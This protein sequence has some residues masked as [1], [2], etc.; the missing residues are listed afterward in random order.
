MQESQNL[1]RHTDV[2]EKSATAFKFAL[3]ERIRVHKTE[4][5]FQIKVGKQ[6]IPNTEELTHQL[7]HN[8][9][10]E[11]QIGIEQSERRSKYFPTSS[12]AS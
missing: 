7:H 4:N 1:F 3:G 10:Q 11:M 8:Q 9:D 6:R 2:K 5:S 12:Y